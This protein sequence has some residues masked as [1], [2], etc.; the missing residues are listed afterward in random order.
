MSLGF[1]SEIKYLLRKY[2]AQF[3][4]LLVGSAVFLYATGGRILD[5][6]H[7]SWLKAT[8]WFRGD[9]A[10][11]QL[12]WQFFRET[13]FL[14][15]PLGVNTRYG[16]EFG[17]SIFYTD[18]LPL[19]A[20]PLK[21]FSQLLPET[22]QYFGLWIWLVFV[23]QAVLAW[24]ISRRWH[25]SLLANSLV[26]I[27]VCLS[28]ILTFRLVHAA[29]AS[30]FVILLAIRMYVSRQA[31]IALWVLLACAA[32]A[33]QFYLL[34][35]VF[36]L[37]IASLYDNRENPARSAFRIVSMS[38]ATAATLYVVGATS[39]QRFSGA[40]VGAGEIVDSNRGFRW[41]PLALVDPIAFGGG[42]ADESWSQLIPDVLPGFHSE[43]FS[44]LGSGI[45]LVL[46]PYLFIKTA[47]LEF[48]I[49][50]LRTSVIYAVCA[51]VAVS[52]DVR[53]LGYL[54]LLVIGVVAI[55]AAIERRSW[56][57]RRGVLLVCALAT[58]YSIGNPLGEY[59]SLPILDLV[60]SNFR[61]FS[62]YSWLVYYL[63]IFMLIAQL[64]RLASRRMIILIL[65]LVVA[66]E[67]YDSRDAFRESRQ[68]LSG[69]PE[70]MSPMKSSRW[71]ELLEGRSAAVSYPPAQAG[72]PES[73]SEPAAPDG[74]WFAIADFAAT[75]R[76]ETNA[77]YQARIDAS[78]YDFVTRQL[79][80]ALQED[81]LSSSTVYFIFDET[82]W[83]E[84]RQ[85]ETY[86]FIGEIDGY[87]VIAP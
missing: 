11:H 36:G 75:H 42:F 44:Y 10:T 8:E 37:A 45:L 29:L 38:L 70:W 25:Q 65:L 33:I 85:R 32:T 53:L 81:R 49:P 62:R 2:Q 6:G 39:I 4:G 40:N 50:V 67:V 55:S 74:A 63:L 71:S 1:L 80:E 56:V 43:G 14:Q 52:I 64:A 48:G 30:H 26:A 69:A 61:V 24:Q 16:M 76:L 58:A 78:L 54:W 17:S 59:P 79:R 13:A 12:A 31:R 21:F 87:R 19:L 72:V 7:D 73:S 51:L 22:F 5:V 20:I 34:P 41:Q 77:G 28:P 86:E 46:V 27:L 60:S 66:V 83:E 35:F 23:L 18:S 15:W 82:I 9:P 84:L 68:R 57:N 3:G 47:E